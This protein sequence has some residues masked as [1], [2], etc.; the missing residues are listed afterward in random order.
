[1]KQIKNSGVNAHKVWS[2]VAL[3]GLF[4]CGIM[5][6]WT[7]FSAKPRQMVFTH[8]QCESL[9]N[10]ISSAIRNNEFGQLND[11]QKIFARNC[12]GFVPK[13]VTPAPVKVSN[14]IAPCARIEQILSAQIN[15]NAGDVSSLAYNSVT[16]AQLVAQGC[17]ENTAKWQKLYDDTVAVGYGID[18]PDFVRFVSEFS[19]N[20]PVK[21]ES[22][23]QEIENLLK[24]KIWH[25]QSDDVD[26]RL[27]NADVYST[28]SVRGCPENSD[29]YKSLAL[30]ELEIVS[31]LSDDELSTDDTE[32]V[33]DTYKKLNMQKQAQEFLNKIQK[34]TNPAI[35]FIL[36]MEKIINE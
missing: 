34:L 29:M 21:T 8:E 27:H 28:L 33:I 20:N 31:A 4:A 10:K 19:D 12:S 22:T 13:K 24:N 18:K 35:D 16:Y 14:D 26:A 5:I 36:A 25:G 15:E 7:V 6:G 3:V 11:A 30:R 2:A 1:M 32:I 9:S 17:P 23:C